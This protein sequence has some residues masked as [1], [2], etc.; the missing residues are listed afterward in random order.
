M[1]SE[2]SRRTIFL[3]GGAWPFP[4]P[5]V[6]EL[7]QAVP[8]RHWSLV[9]GLMVQLHC[10]ARAVEPP[11]PTSDIDA[12]AHV[13]IEGQESL[14]TLK[15]GLTGLGYHAVP[16]LSRKTLSIATGAVMTAKWCKSTS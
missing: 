9:G 8:C 16:P 5:E 3:A 7:E 2:T 4:W 15:A 12:L 6:F 14:A 13:E 1:T 11:R 10:Y